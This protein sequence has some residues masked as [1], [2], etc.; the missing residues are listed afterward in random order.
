MFIS[1]ALRCEWDLP[2][3]GSRVHG[4]SDDVL[5]TMTEQR[6]GVRWKLVRVCSGA[7][8]QG[9]V[10]VGVICCGRRVVVA[11][12]A[13]WRVSIGWKVRTLLAR[14]HLQA[15]RAAVSHS[16]VL[17]APLLAQVASG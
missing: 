8:C 4:G 16:W 6:V 14:A 17:L 12:S 10:V 11:A 7:H 5:S 2:Y 9:H 1:D 15:R 13:G 3:C